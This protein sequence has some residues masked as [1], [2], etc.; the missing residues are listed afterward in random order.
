MN[1]DM[2][3]VDTIR[4]NFPILNQTI[5]GKPLVYLDNAATTQKPQSVLDQMTEYYTI[6]NSNI[7][8]G[9][10]YLSDQASTAYEEARKKVQHF[11]HAE[12]TQEI[13][14]TS[15][16][17]E[18]INLVANTFGNAFLHESE[19]I[20][21]SEMEHHSNLVPWQIVCQN[22][23]ADLKILP[24]YD[25]GIL[26]I[27]QLDKL[28]SDQTKLIAV[29]YVSNALGI[30]NPIEKIIELS[31][32][33]NIPVLV[34]GAQAVQHMP[35][36]VQ[37]L[38]CDFFAFSGHKM[39]APTGIGILYGK[40]KW[41]EKLPPYQTGGGMIDSV[42]LKSTQFSDLPHKFEAGTPN[43]AGAIGLHAAIKFLNKLGLHDISHYEK[44]IMDYLIKKLIRFPNLTIFGEEADKMGAISF[45]LDQ[46][47]AT[48][49]GLILDK[50][51]I[52]VRTGTHCAEPVMAHFN[53]KGTVRASLGIY[54][55]KS[56]ID[57]LIHG[58]IKAQSMLLG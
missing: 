15:G 16:T 41:L 55:T 24:F 52:A 46:I 5:H 50:L 49:I 14:F 21:V 42:S 27:D 32:H 10:H 37:A 29:T 12:K 31:H 44:E 4:Q 36:D 19:N 30:I 22:K 54:N 47:D 9:V 57:Q 2:F 20:I 23:R 6:R 1:P 34:D 8:R 13:I 48:D 17:T 25:S 33:R 39:Y 58:L 45:N 28:I 40:E 38:D 11:I 3:N 7:H 53:I 43:I 35:I 56:D 26:A 51:G 18:S